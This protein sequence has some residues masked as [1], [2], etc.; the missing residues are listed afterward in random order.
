MRRCRRSAAFFLAASLT[1][2]AARAYAAADPPRAGEEVEDEA[3]ARF[4]QGVELLQKGAWSD[5]LVAFSTSARLYP[6]PQAINNAAICLRKL[7]RYD[8]ALDQVGALLLDFPDLPAEK[9]QAAEREAAELAKLVGAISVEGAEPGAQIT[10]D[11]RDRGIFPAPRPFR[12]LTGSHLVRVLQEGFLPFEARVEVVAG[13]TLRITVSRQRRVPE[14]PPPA[15]GPA[16]RA[17]PPAR[18]FGIELAGAMMIS[19]SFGGEIM[20]TCTKRC[21]ATPA[22]G[23]Y[24]V[25]RGSYAIGASLDLG[26]SAGFLAGRK[27]L[28]DR[29]TP[30]HPPPSVPVGPVDD[31]LTLSGGLLGIWVGT[32][33]GKQPFLDLRFGAGAMLG[34]MSDVRSW[35][36]AETHAA[37]PFGATSFGGFL[38]LDPEVRVGVRVGEHLSLAVGVE[39]MMLLAVAP[40][41]WPENRAFSDPRYGIFTFRSESLAG[42]VLFLVLPS[43]SARYTF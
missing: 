25:L 28:T 36:D 15:P 18:R 9:R 3:R 33:L 41:A 42:P 1:T 21:D 8:E 11:G 40:P 23:G 30:L 2:F 10:I 29:R 31:T 26:I 32:R 35:T 22:L 34:R 37:G 43:V 7:G 17:A 20:E 16:P 39:A 14:A 5:A 27:T 6:T 38:Y 24:G 4:E 19:P 13:E 12:V